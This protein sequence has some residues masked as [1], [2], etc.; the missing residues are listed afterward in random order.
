MM[1]SELLNPYMVLL[2]FFIGACVGYFFKQYR[3]ANDQQ[4][5]L[6]KIAD[7]E[8]EIEF[9]KKGEIQAAAQLAALTRDREALLIEKSQLEVATKLQ[10]EKLATTLD[11]INQTKE[12]MQMSFRSISSESLK[13]NHE[14][15]VRLARNSLESLHS[16][17]KMDLEKR[18]QSIE[19]IL[20][21][22]KETLQR[23]EVQVQTSEKERLQQ[24]SQFSET[25]RN[26][27]DSEQKLRVETAGLAKALRAPQVRGRWGEL[28]L[29]RVVELAGMLDHCDFY[30]QVHQNGEDSRL[31]PDL[32]VKL[33]GGKNIV[34]DAKAVIDSF[35]EAIQTSDETYRKEKFAEHAQHI[36]A[37][38]TDLS[39]KAYWTQFQPSPEF[40]V[41]FL[42]G[43][44]FFSAA[45]EYD[46][47][48][49]EQSIDQKVILATPTTL[50]ALLKAVAYGW[51]Q[52]T[53]QENSVRI[54]ALAKELSK[55]LK[56]MVDH[57]AGL[58]QNLNRSVEQYNRT[59]ASFETRV[60]VTARKFE[61]LQ[62]STELTDTLTPVEKTPRS[63]ESQ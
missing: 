32:L 2:V 15:F 47:S 24:S 13:E 3:T 7:Y 50:I 61:E 1:V 28:Q 37:R 31:R 26:L 42:P 41:L 10:Q 4:Q 63:L 14:V 43:E 8:A 36:R 55:R 20:Q 18:S 27:L 60:L 9:L 39:R 58:G 44:S 51:K 16:Q 59:V 62:G 34:I 29:R 22:I 21:P 5:H 54:S 19:N 17:S 45:L 11:F 56:D 49:L 23:V 35:L 6:K 52:D 30:E 57:F 46:P 40:V 12:Q 25:I 38:I 48:L 53:L 33:P